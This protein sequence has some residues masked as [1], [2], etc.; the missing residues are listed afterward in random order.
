MR[1]RTWSD[2]ELAELERQYL[3]GGCSLRQVRI[4]NRSPS[5]VMNRAWLLGLAEER[6]LENSR[7]RC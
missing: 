3:E 4:P 2:E 1:G 6:A 7:D 5:S